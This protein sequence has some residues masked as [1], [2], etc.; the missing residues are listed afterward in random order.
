[1]GSMRLPVAGMLL[2]VIALALAGCDKPAM[3]SA[4]AGAA[5]GIPV[6]TLPIL[7]GS[8]GALLY[9]TYCVACHTENIH[10]REKKLVT[11]MDS[12]ERQ[13]RRWQASIELRWTDEEIAVV[14]RYL[15]AVYYGFPDAGD[16]GLLDEKKPDHALGKN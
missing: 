16:K 5:A 15:N 4:D 6:D 12:L 14:V 9:S 1:M 13:V 8:R 10:W 3:L 2:A 11:D 7:A